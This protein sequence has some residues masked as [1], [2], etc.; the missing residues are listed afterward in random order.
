MSLL[1]KTLF[2]ATAGS[3]LSI[4]IIASTSYGSDL[5]IKDGTV[6]MSK[7]AR[8]R[9]TPHKIELIS[10]SRQHELL[11]ELETYS[12]ESTKRKINEGLLKQLNF[13]APSPLSDIFLL[14]THNSYN[15]TSYGIKSL[16]AEQTL[17]IKQQLDLGVRFLM[18][19]VK[20]CSGELYAVHKFCL[21]KLTNAGKFEEF[22]Q[23][24]RD[25]MDQ[26][27]DES[28]LIDIENR[29][30]Q[31]YDEKLVSIIRDTMG[32]YLYRTQSLIKYPPLNK[33]RG[34]ALFFLEFFRDNE[35]DNVALNETFFRYSAPNETSNISHDLLYRYTFY[36][37]YPNNLV[38]QFRNHKYTPQEF[39]E[40]NDH[41]LLVLFEGTN[42]TIR[43]STYGV[44]VKDISEMMYSGVNIVS[45]DT[46]DESKVS[47]E[48]LLASIWTFDPFSMDLN[49]QD[50]TLIDPSTWLWKHASCSE[51]KPVACFNHL[52]GTWSITPKI[53]P[54]SQAAEACKAIGAEFM[55]PH[56]PTDITEISPFKETWI[57]AQD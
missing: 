41:G 7:P 28:L 39:K 1:S 2:L 32:S 20:D 52:H 56:T 15:S 54:A 16:L 24:I 3:S 19:D 57:N 22:I 8:V 35:K 10:K 26:H 34:H 13:Q 40:K 47:L 38:N 45:L 33:I 18:L 31:K 21:S 46:I 6:Q 55:K 44:S 17:T 49:S 29:N 11:H 37:R 51:S 4:A 27:R 12:I 5:Q 9:I 30:S 36:P 23:E 14:G 48:K 50:C 25:W 53:H 43:P 42:L